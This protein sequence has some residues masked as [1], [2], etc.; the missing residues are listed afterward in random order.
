MIGT[1]TT[2]IGQRVFAFDGTR[3]FLSLQASE[4]FRKLAIGNNWNRLRIGILCGIGGTSGSVLGADMAVGVCTYSSANPAGLFGYNTTNWV[5]MRFDNGFGFD[6]NTY[7]GGANPYFTSPTYAA[8]AKV[9]RTITTGNQGSGSL[10][11]AATT[12]TTLQRRS[13]ISVD[14]IKGSPTYSFNIW[15]SLSAG[16]VVVDWNYNNLVEYVQQ[17]LAG[18][19]GGL[20]GPTALVS[21]SAVNFGVTASETAGPLDSICISWRNYFIPLEL[22]AVAVYRLY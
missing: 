14:I 22:Y 21:F 2:I 13:I 4:I 18:S 1:G 12:G 15:G 9:G 5:G 17:L 11:Y 8:V 7:N 3:N 10:F 16:T 6:T 20:I 19:N